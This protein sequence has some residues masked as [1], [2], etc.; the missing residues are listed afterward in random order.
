M[1]RGN[2]DGGLLHPAP[3]I[4]G[5]NVRELCVGSSTG[6]CSSS[7]SPSLSSPTLVLSFRSTIVS[8][9][10]RFSWMNPGASLVVLVV[11]MVSGLGRMFTEKGVATE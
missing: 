2:S 1:E 10:T 3:T 4:C 5:R 9:V 7:P 8:A 11:D 6:V